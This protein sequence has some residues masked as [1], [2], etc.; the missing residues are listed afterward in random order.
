MIL[1]LYSIVP[2]GIRAMLSECFSSEI[3]IEICVGKE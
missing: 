1:L 2:S 3:L